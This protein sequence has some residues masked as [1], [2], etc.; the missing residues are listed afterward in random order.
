MLAR[1]TSNLSCLADLRG[2]QRIEGDVTHQESLAAALQG[3]E[4]VYHCAGRVEMPRFMTPAIWE[5]NVSGTENLLAA[6][7][8]AGVGRLVYCSTVDAL[9]LPEGEQPANED[10]C[11]NW[12]RLGVE[13]AYA[14]SKYEA[15]RR[16]QKAN[17]NGL[18][19]ILVCPTF[20][21]GAYDPHP[22]S[23]RL[24]QQ[25]ARSPWR[26][27]TGGGNNFVD[28][29]D[30]A[31]AMIAAASCGRSGETYILGGENLPYVEIQGLI[32]QALGRK[33]GPCL[34]L[35]R[36]FFSIA[37]W[38]GDACEMFTGRPNVLNTPLTRLSAMRHYYDSRKAERELGVQHSPLPAA[39]ERAVRWLRGAGML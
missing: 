15:H 7:R 38:L 33:P 35:P 22:S 25:V 4:V 23:G 8:L 14:R 3:V 39:L 2:W 27:D 31:R 26:L 12:D 32:H 16:V 11:W 29:L 9:G 10:T 36:S 1:P 37:G 20:M 21:L 28:V 18:E 24:I 34:R 13:N 19:T 6:C 5:V 30:A 17:G